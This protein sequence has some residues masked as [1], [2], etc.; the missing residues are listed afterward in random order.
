MT[1]TPAKIEIRNLSKAFGAKTVLDGLNLSIPDKT[2]MVVIGG[3]GTGKSV[4]IK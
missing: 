2:S 4:L 1:H 3:S